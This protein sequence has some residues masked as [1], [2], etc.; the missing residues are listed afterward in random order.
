VAVAAVVNA[1]LDELSQADIFDNDRQLV[2]GK[3]VESAGRANECVSPDPA[4]LMADK[5]IAIRA[6]LAKMEKELR[7]AAA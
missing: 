3:D 1:V 7:C 6:A 5:I 4:S 2:A